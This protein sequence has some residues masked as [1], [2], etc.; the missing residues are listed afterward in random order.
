MCKILNLSTIVSTPVCACAT[1]CRHLQLQAADCN[2]IKLM[3]H[4]HV[5]NI[6]LMGIHN[7]TNWWK[8]RTGLYRWG[9]N[10]RWQKIMKCLQTEDNKRNKLFVSLP[11]ILYVL[12]LKYKKI[13]VCTYIF[14]FGIFRLNIFNEP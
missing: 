7:E 6:D 5:L 12:C 9:Y 14:L 4:R 3:S 2:E 10:C 8:A 11:N 1:S 13:Y